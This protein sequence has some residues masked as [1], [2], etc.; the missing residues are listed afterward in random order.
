MDDKKETPVAQPSDYAPEGGN[1]DHGLHTQQEETLGGE[2]AGTNYID[3][4]QDTQ[5]VPGAAPALNR[6]DR[7]PT[8]WHKTEDGQFN[9]RSQCLGLAVQS[10]GPEQPDSGTDWTKD[11]IRRAD[12]FRKYLETGSQE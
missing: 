12:R 4:A 9:L 6:A 3:Q 11:T 10:L 7:D 5:Y 2:E 1:V 8:P